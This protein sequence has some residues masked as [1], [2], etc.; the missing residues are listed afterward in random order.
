MAYYITSNN[1]LNLS[2]SKHFSIVLLS[3]IKVVFRCSV[4]LT[5]MSYG[6][7]WSKTVIGYTLTPYR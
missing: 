1:I 4:L 3:C 5:A 6:F 7:F 2:F